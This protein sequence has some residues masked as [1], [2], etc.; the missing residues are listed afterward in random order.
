MCGYPSDQALALIRQI[1][2][3]N[4]GF[5]SGMV[6]WCD[7]E[8]NG[9]WVVTLRCA[10]VQGQHMRL[11]AGAGVV[12][13]SQPASELAETSA[14]FKTMLNALGMAAQETL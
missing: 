11:F 9:E 1:E 14:K 13:E 6:G 8:G 12:A 3:F 5:Y 4:R 10:L 7:A 2:P